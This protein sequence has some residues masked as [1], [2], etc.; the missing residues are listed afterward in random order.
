MKKP[1][2]KLVV[3]SETIRALRALDSRDLMEV[4]AGFKLFAPRANGTVSAAESG[5]NNCP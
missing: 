4:V 2:R 3:R 5:D 1:I